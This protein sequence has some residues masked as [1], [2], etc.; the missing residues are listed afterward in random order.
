MAAGG[1]PQRTILVC[2]WAAEEFGL[3]GSKHWVESN[4][5]KLPYISNYFNRDGGPTVPTSHDCSRG[6]VRRLRKGMQTA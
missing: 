2:L 6:N 5:D 3:L 1:K 4:K